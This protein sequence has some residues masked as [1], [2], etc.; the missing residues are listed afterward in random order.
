[1]TYQHFRSV[2]K[3]ESLIIDSENIYGVKETKF[4]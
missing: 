1:M 2:N 3:H 4:L